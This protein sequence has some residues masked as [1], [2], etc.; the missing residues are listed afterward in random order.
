LECS[1]AIYYYANCA[2]CSGALLPPSPP[3]EKDTARQDQARQSGTRD[4]AG[5]SS[6]L[7]PD[8]TAG[9]LRSVDVK[10]SQS[11][12][13]SRDQRRLSLRDRPHLNEV[14]IVEPRVQETKGLIICAGGYSQ[15]ELG[16]G[17]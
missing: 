11:A 10:I 3:A 2:G 9:E 6:Q 7:A 12:F 5:D 1:N 17:P 13:D 15:R 4:G 14:R 8:L 16:I